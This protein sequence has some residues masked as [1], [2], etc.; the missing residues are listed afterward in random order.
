MNVSANSVTSTMLLDRLQ[1]SPPD[2]AAGDEFVER[3]GRRIQAWCCQWGLPRGRCRGRGPI[4]ARQAAPR[5]AH[6]PSGPRHGSFADNSGQVQPKKAT[7]ELER[8]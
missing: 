6:R 2:Q 3:Y 7:R 8:V 4:G 5:C 1:Q